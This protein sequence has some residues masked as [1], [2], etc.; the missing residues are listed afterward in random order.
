MPVTERFTVMMLLRRA[1]NDT[2]EVPPWRTP[3]VIG[4]AAEVGVGKRQMQRVL[5][6]LDCHRWLKHV[7]GQGRG[8]KSVY[9]LLPDG[10]PGTPCLSDCP[11]RWAVKGAGDTTLNLN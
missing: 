10:K 4:L 3:R 5:A 1:H 7:P 2:L 8:R 9:L 6:H 11:H